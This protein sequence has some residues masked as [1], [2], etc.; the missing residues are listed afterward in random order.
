MAT[1][2]DTRYPM[3]IEPIWQRDSRWKDA[4]LGYNAKKTGSTIGSVGCLL[5]SIAMLSRYYTGIV[6]T[7]TQVDWLLKSHNGYRDDNIIN[8]FAIGESVGGFRFE[9]MYQWQ[10][11]PA[12]IKVIANHIRDNVPVLMKVDF[13]PDTSK[14]EP[15]FVLGVAMHGQDIIV[16]DP[17]TGQ[18]QLLLKKYGKPGWTLERAIY[19]A[20]IYRKYEIYGT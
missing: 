10:D 7:P 16:D 3:G 4:P 2:R 18:L 17:W 15:H 6:W 12:D 19:S 13:N 20:T 1:E 14:V 8:H 9:K 11:V 5:S